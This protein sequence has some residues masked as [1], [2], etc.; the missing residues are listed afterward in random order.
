MW[1]KLTE[2]IDGPKTKLIAGPQKLYRF[3]VTPGVEVMNMMFAG[4]KAVWVSWRFTA[5]EQ[6]PSLR[7][8]KEVIGAYVTAGAWIHLYSYLDRLQENALHCGT[9][10]IIY[11]QPT[12]GPQLFQTGHRLG[13]MHSELKPREYID[14][15]V[16]GGLSVNLDILMAYWPG[17]SR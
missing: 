4:E 7:H 15:F 6:I 5:E 16:S 13:S 3:L 9:H 17:Y 1:R 12:D 10:S 11:I 2:R 14:E 8:T